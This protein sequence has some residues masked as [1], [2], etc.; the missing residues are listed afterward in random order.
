MDSELSGAP[1]EGADVT[2]VSDAGQ[3]PAPAPA[4]PDRDA[5]GKVNTGTARE[6]IA[7][8][9][10]AAG[11]GQDK[12]AESQEAAPAGE[13]QRDATGKFAPKADAAPDATGK[14]ADGQQPQ[15]AATDAAPPS[16]LSKAAQEAWQQTPDVVRTEIARME[17]EL[18]QGIE[19]YKTAFEPIKRFDDMAKSGG[20]TLDK[21]LE[22]YVGIENLLRSD[23]LKGMAAICQNMGV[24]PRAMAQA[25]LGAVDPGAPAQGQTPEVAA[26]KAEIASLK[27]QITGVSA[28]FRNRDTRSTIEKFASERPD[29]DALAEPISHMLQTG[30]AKDLQ[31]AYDMARRLHPE[32][33]HV[34]PEEKAPPAHTRKAAM[35]ITGTPPTAGSNPAPRKNGVETARDTLMETFAQAGIRI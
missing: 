4:A 22:S 32:L 16:R 24:D 15:P 10:R 14:P 7:E 3:A 8:A 31:A 27:E 28:E 35:S 12:P 5:N 26:L 1:A 17:R 21:A 30:F 33:A 34:A 29:F 20:T 2:V 13:R 19:K 11:I 23:P 6:A 9:M 18:V 25:M